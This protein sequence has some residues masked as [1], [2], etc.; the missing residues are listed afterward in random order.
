[1]I[2]RLLILVLLL[3]VSNG[4]FWTSNSTKI[5]QKTRAASLSVKDD[6]GAIR[7]TAFVIKGNRII[8]NYHV[9]EGLSSIFVSE[10]DSGSKIKV[11]LK[12][13]D[14]FNDIAVL[15]TYAKFENYLIFNDK[16][17][18]L[19][20]PVHACGNGLNGAEGAFTTGSISG[21]KVLEGIRYLQHSAPVTS[22]NSGGPLVNIKG[23]LVGINTLAATGYIKNAEGEV[24]ATTLSST[25]CFALP[26]NTIKGILEVQDLYDNSFTFIEF[27]NDNSILIIIVFIFIISYIVYLIAQKNNI[28]KGNRKNKVFKTKHLYGKIK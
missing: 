14:A 12:Y 18:A 3:F 8:T 21:Y 28:D 5:S 7:G 26:A 17:L 11:T 13:Y 25:M 16:A 10:F 22:G 19:G 20:T 4:C 27:I 24:V 23:E 6:S 15:E 1:M 9:V 2:Y